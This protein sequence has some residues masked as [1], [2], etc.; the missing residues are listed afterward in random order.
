[1][2]SKA[3]PSIN[4]S[5]V[6]GKKPVN[7]S[8]QNGNKIKH[9]IVPPEK[10]NQ[11]IKD[12]GNKGPKDEPKQK[13]ILSNK[14]AISTA[15]EG[16]IGSPKAIETERGS[17]DVK[18]VSLNGGVSV[19]ATSPS[20]TRKISLAVPI[21]GSVLRD[22]TNTEDDRVSVGSRRDSVRLS[23]DM[24]SRKS[25]DIR[26][27]AAVVANLNAANDVKPKSIQTANDSFIRSAIPCLPLGVSILFLVMNIIL[28]G[29]GK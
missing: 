19:G 1:M 7:N 9:K 12:N 5:K 15:K 20:G 23:L 24:G 21:P 26:A 17:P 6:P 14:N 10:E 27:Q 11:D 8:E 2:S 18:H 22:S 3:S 16:T 28:P 4:A 13:S 29:L 25:I